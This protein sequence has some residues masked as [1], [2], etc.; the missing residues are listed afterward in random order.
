[1][2]GEMDGKVLFDSET[3]KQVDRETREKCAIPIA[4]PDENPYSEEDEEQVMERLRELGYV[5]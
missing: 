3:R 2:P 4:P 1:V 5:A